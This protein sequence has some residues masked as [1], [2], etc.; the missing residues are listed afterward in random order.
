MAENNLHSRPVKA[1]KRK[2]RR[3]GSISVD[4]IISGAFEVAERVS[5]E[6]LNMPMLAEHLDVGVT[7]IYWY[8]GRKEGLLAAMTDRAMEMYIFATPFAEDGDWEESLRNHARHMRNTFR[9][10]PVLTQLL[11]LRSPLGLEALHSSLAAESLQIAYSNIESVIAM[12][13]EAGFTPEDA[14]DTYS[15]L[16]VHTRGIVMLEWIAST[17]TDRLGHG[18]G[19]DRASA[20]LVAD[21]VARGHRIGV[22]EGRVFEFGLDALIDHSKRLLD[23]NKL[24]ERARQRRTAGAPVIESPPTVDRDRGANEAADRS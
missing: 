7:S 8:F 12:L 10:H 23:A 24:I 16:I 21:L 14:I 18:L 3:R 6:S 22:A 17:E 20:P 13:S 15:A 9:E 19:I 5:L 2:R 1:V 4:E 11:L